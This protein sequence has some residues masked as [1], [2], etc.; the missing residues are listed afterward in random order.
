VAAA[1]AAAALTPIATLSQCDSR[2]VGAPWD[3]RLACG[4]QLPVSTPHLT[5]WDNALQSPFNRPWR[6][7][8]TARLV[9]RVKR[10]AA[11]Y[12]ARYGQR[13]VVGDLSR[14]QGGPFGREFGGDGHASHQNGLDVDIYYPRRDGAE[15]PPFRVSAVHRRRAQWLLDRSARHASVVFTGPNLALRRRSPRV[16]Y[17]G[18]HDDHLHL[19]I[20]P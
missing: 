1:L 9:A 11:D 4:T 2:A 15:I 5:T 16:K 6:R 7:W 8:G 17:L 14:P 18:N 13:I 20:G 3:G 12:Q 19:R 10:I